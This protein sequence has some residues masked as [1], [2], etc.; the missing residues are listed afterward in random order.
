MARKTGQSVRAKVRKEA[1]E[2]GAR[3]GRPRT[4]VE[5]LPKN[6]KQIMR[7]EAMGGG[8]TTAFMVKLKIG[9]TAL[10]TLLE[11]SDEFR[12]TYEECLLEQQYWWEMKGRDMAD[13]AQGNA[14]VWSL[15]MTNR[16]NWKSGRN[17]VVGDRNAPIHHNV[18]N[19]TMTK[20]E[21]IAELQARGLPTT[22]FG[23][24]ENIEP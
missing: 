3:T 17:E 18:N 1:L 2:G 7:A 16:F 22:I 14:T 6:W 8:G 11:A 4:K 15:N 13:G 5:D 19:S 21:I 24:D 20:E 23:D 12:H 10:Q 9:H